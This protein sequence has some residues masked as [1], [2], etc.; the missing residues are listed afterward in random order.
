VNI[1]GSFAAYNTSYNVSRFKALHRYVMETAA[2]TSKKGLVSSCKNCGKCETHCPQSI[3]I[4]QS[5]KTVGK[6]LE[7]IWFKAG[8]AA[9]RLFT[10]MKAKR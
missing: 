3:P 2:L 4:R 7:P 6:R 8:I 1:P 10:M 9:A 5:L